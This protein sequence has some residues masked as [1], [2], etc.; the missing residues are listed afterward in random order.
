MK[1]LKNE[2]QLRKNHIKPGEWV[3]WLVIR[4]SLLSYGVYN[5]CL[6][7]NWDQLNAKKVAIE[8]NMFGILI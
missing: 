4:S 1:T 2:G 8:I 7:V 5:D 6:I 3:G